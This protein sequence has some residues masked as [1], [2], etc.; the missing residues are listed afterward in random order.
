MASSIERQ[1]SQAKRKR[2]GKKYS[3]GKMIQE[4]ETHVASRGSRTKLRFLKDT[5]QQEKLAAI[6]RH[7]DFMLLLTDGHPEF[8]DRWIDD[9]SIRV[10]DCLAN[11]EQY[12]VDRENDT[13]SSLC[14]AETQKA[15][16][17]SWR[18]SIQFFEDAEKLE[19]SEAEKLEGSEADNNSVIE[20]FSKLYIE[21]A[22]SN[23][24]MT[25]TTGNRDPENAEVR[26]TQ[27][28]NEYGSNSPR[29][30]DPENRSPE[31]GKGILLEANLT[32]L[33][34]TETKPHVSGE[35]EVR[36]PDDTSKRLIVSEAA[37]VSEGTRYQTYDGTRGQTHHLESTSREVKFKRSPQ[38]WR[39]PLPNR[40]LQSTYIIDKYPP[41]DRLNPDA[42]PFPAT[43][44][45]Y[46]RS[47][48]NQ[49][50]ERHRDERCQ[51]NDNRGSVRQSVTQE[52]ERSIDS[53]I[54][55]L[56]LE[57]LNVQP[58]SQSCDIQMQM[59]IQ[60][61]L[62]TQIIPQFDGSADRWV[63]F[64]SSFY[65]MVHRQP[66]L[67]SFQK[68]TYL[69]QHLT[70]EPLRAVGGYP[71]DSQGYIDSLQRLKYMFGNPS[72]V[73][74]ATIK[75]VTNGSQLSDD[76]ETM[77]DF[78]YSLSECV[79]TLKKMNYIADIHSTSVLRQT[80]R[81]LPDR[82]LHK[83]AEH[84]FRIRKKEEPNLCHVERWLQDRIMAAKDPYLPSPKKSK[85]NGHVGGNDRDDERKIVCSH[86]GE[87]HKIYQ[88]EEFKRKSS[89]GK[90]E[91]VKS[92]LLCFNCLQKGHGVRDC[93]VRRNCSAPD[94]NRR[95]HTWL[96]KAL[97]KNSDQVLKRGNGEQKQP[98]VHTDP[99]Q[100]SKEEVRERGQPPDSHSEGK[101]ISATGIGQHVFLQIVPVMI[102]NK[103]RQW[104]TTYALLDSGSQCTLIKK[105]LCNK[106]G[107]RGR[108]ETIKISTIKDHED[109]RVKTL[110]IS[111]SSADKG[112]RAEVESVHSIEDSKFRMPSQ[113]IPN[114]IAES[115]E[116]QYIK[117][118]NIANVTSGQV[119]MLIGADVPKALISSEVK[120]GGHGL[121]H[122]SKT[123]F[124]WSLIGSYDKGGAK[125][126]K[127]LTAH[128]RMDEE[129]SLD[130]LV[131]DFWE[132]ESFG[133]KIQE[134]RPLSIQDRQAI[135]RLDEETVVKDG[136]YVVPM[137]WKGSVKLPNNY[138]QAERRLNS[139]SK[140]L[141]NDSDFF[142]MYQNNISSYLEKGYARRLEVSEVEERTDRTWYLP[143]HGVIEPHKP[144]KIRTVFDAAAE[145]AGTSLN[146]SLFTGPDLLNSL[147]GIL[148]RFRR[149]KVA[150]TADIEAMFHRVHLNEGDTDAVRF[151]WRDD[152]NSKS[153][154]EHYK[155]LVHI[156]GATDSTC[157]SAYALRRAA[158]DQQQDFSDRV[159]KTVLK[160][161]YVDDLLKSV[162]TTEEANET[163]LP[164][165][166]LLDNRGFRVTKFNSNSAEFLKNIPE[167]RR[168]KENITSLKIDDK[169][170]VSR[171]LGVRWNLTKDCFY[172]HS[173]EPSANNTK[174]G[175]LKTTSTVYDPLGLL[176]PFTL[177]ARLILQELWRAKYSWDDSI[178]DNLA[179]EWNRWL[180]ELRQIGT[181]EVPRS[182]DI[183]GYELQ[184]HT[185]CDGSEKAFSA[186]SYV[187][188]NRGGGV[189]CH[190]LMAKSRV[191]PLKKITLPRLELQG[192]VM[193][194]RL[195][196]TI[197]DEAE[198]TFSAIHFWTDS[199]LNL[200][201]ISNDS[202]RFK[203][204][205]SNRV[206]EIREKSEPDQWHHIP[207][208]QNPSDLGTRETNIHRLT[209][210][211]IWFKG[212]EILYRPEESW[213]ETTI[214]D[215]DP[216]D[217]EIKKETMN[218][219]I[220]T[221]RPMID[222]TRFSK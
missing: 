153:P 175:I 180:E 12:F 132:T 93:M 119:E 6:E 40:C 128:L 219:N 102:L 84:S 166:R 170:A 86:C 109:I 36:T 76:A 133:T 123:P 122:A 154:P 208:K 98:Q 165:I 202:K 188:V 48:V 117:G 46:N 163:F 80:L 19:G 8:N 58:L 183:N 158:L 151:L 9:L 31:P 83:W 136:H 66:Y 62:P 81:R 144:G 44:N 126:K 114:D 184:L 60:Q 216:D 111:I 195:H 23:N 100:A 127:V 116:W 211:P 7:E 65:D 2:N 20:A 72:I 193:A 105:S 135:E 59:L 85:F 176:T 38:E 121:P 143:H 49:T 3:I 220:K 43:I 63:T 17:E 173:V 214:P 159:I 90:L 174:R 82:Y 185:F 78:Y 147:I 77:T 137:L 28:M 16:I 67:D 139:L 141:R 13:P 107:L 69:V 177:K 189:T 124:G 27:A 101:L 29:R 198:M 52:G 89:Q 138:A 22:H 199:T 71:N 194:V 10:N 168:A 91:T 45:K 201:Y 56:N 47:R 155:M 55:E 150:V 146:K 134:T 97:S 79:N 196:Q 160:S 34:N 68:R 205:V 218:L 51:T 125:T 221:E 140:R 179:K 95:H 33:Q 37:D 217:E 129:D 206:F 171:A 191:A 104:V 110:N 50:N 178:D 210:D 14:S 11:I 94:C 74:Q 152:P 25:Q 148:L 26:D 41:K 118:L 157:C 209:S 207:G 130:R 222:Y 181:I 156:F 186:C 24:T 192:A 200:Q 197:V 15:R 57:N 32:R 190:L 75:K 112:F 145:V 18:Q 54:D 87:N 142:R 162:Q 4:I 213:G 212:P 169:P 172:F 161:F 120:F 73:A 99:D 108:M 39:D 96:H 5:L 149:Y 103:Y 131:R 70:G 215:I 182:L 21:P 106:L 92:K 53:W 64:I 113:A 88:C 204:F 30:N 61:R 203:V 167:E 35:H 164:L 187:R 1:I 42:T 115:R